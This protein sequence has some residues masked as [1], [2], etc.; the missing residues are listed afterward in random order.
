MVTKYHGQI[1]STLFELGRD[2]VSK[3]RIKNSRKGNTHPL[4]IVDP[5]TK[6]VVNY[7]PD[8]YFTLRNN[9]KLIFEVVDS[10]GEKQDVLIADVIRSFLVEN[11]DGLFFIHPGPDKVEKAILEA[12]IT[13][14]KGL[15]RKGI[16]EDELPNYRKTGAYLIRR[17]VADDLY[18][19]REILTRYAEEHKWF[20]S[21]GLVKRGKVKR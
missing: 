14:Y 5:R 16:N 8:V 11:V 10:E 21:L 12:L 6:L 4:S 18:K 20:R 13:I 9:R 17:E 3:R 15:V 19:L 1:E 7:Q 2:W